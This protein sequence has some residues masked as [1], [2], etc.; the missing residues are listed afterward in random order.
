LKHLSKYK[1][2]LFFAHLCFVVTDLYTTFLSTPDLAREGAW[3]VKLFNLGWPGVI[4]SSFLYFTLTWTYFYYFSDKR[5][6]PFKI[7][8][9][10]IE[11]WIIRFAWINAINMTI[12]ACL[13]SFSNFLYSFEYIKTKNK[14]FNLIITHHVNI[15]DFLFS[16][17]G[18]IYID[19][20][21][22]ISSIIVFVYIKKIIN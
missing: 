3:D 9:K 14:L 2:E 13:A 21:S 16:K 8:S 22:I 17:I 15:N 20:I 11:N 10:V 7:N 12:A 6:L 19:I 4:F 1:L 5:R 18:M